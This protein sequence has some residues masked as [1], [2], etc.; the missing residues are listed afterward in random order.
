[1]YFPSPSLSQT[2]LAVVSLL[3]ACRVKEAADFVADEEWAE[4]F[5]R[6]AWA[7]AEA[8]AFGPVD[9][10]DYEYF[11]EQFDREVDYLEA[12]FRECAR[13]AEIR[14]VFAEATAGPV[15]AWA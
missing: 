15:S 13:S 11:E 7:V 12:L 1:M 5:V 9:D 3:S 8:F 4:P 10:Y 14:E 6:E 2:V